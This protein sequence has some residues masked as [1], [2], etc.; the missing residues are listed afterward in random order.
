[1]EEKRD[2]ALQKMVDAVAVAVRAHPQQAP[3]AGVMVD[4]IFSALAT[5]VGAQ[6]EGRSAGDLPPACRYFGAAL[7]TADGGPAPVAAM[8]SA[9]RALEPRLSW[10]RRPGAQTSDTDFFDGHANAHLVGA[11]GLER[12]DDIWIGLSLMAPEII[13]PRHRHPPEEVYVA[14]SSGTWMRDDVQLP[15]SNAGDLIH[16]PPEVWHA[17][18]S[19]PDAPLLAIWCLWTGN[20]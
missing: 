5:S 2:P 19:T 16:N 10:Y 20:A 4:R 12:R 18:S 1:M 14:L 7:S 9:L 17:M 11:Q 8:A 15:P 13:Y 6:T 3:E